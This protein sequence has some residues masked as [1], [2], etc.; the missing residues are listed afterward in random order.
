MESQIISS[1]FSIPLLSMIEVPSGSISSIFLRYLRRREIRS[2]FN[3]MEDSYRLTKRILLDKKWTY[4]FIERSLKKIRYLP[5]KVKLIEY[6]PKSSE[7]LGKKL[8]SLEIPIIRVNLSTFGDVELY[9]TV[10]K[11]SFL[12]SFMVRLYNSIEPKEIPKNISFE[13]LRDGLV[14]GLQSLFVLG[15]KHGMEDRKY[16][17]MYKREINRIFKKI[18]KITSSFEP[19]FFDIGIKRGVL[20]REGSRYGENFA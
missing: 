10:L 19:R 15:L 13:D 3:L 2:F 7:D 6:M 9:H 12:L 17:D 11:H 20:I 18:R 1:V 16:V 5:R 4:A 8:K 14:V